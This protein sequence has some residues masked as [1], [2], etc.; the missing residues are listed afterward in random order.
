MWGWFAHINDSCGFLLQRGSNCAHWNPVL[1]PP[2]CW[3]ILWLYRDH[4]QVQDQGTKPGDPV[5]L[6]P[7]QVLSCSHPPSFLTSYLFPPVR[8]GAALHRSNS[9]VPLSGSYNIQPLMILE[10]AAGSDFTVTDLQGKSHT[11][12]GQTIKY[13][14]L[15]LLWIPGCCHDKLIPSY[16]YFF[17]G[18]SH[19]GQSKK[20]KGQVGRLPGNPTTYSRKHPHWAKGYTRNKGKQA[21]PSAN[22]WSQKYLQR[23][24]NGCRLLSISRPQAHQA[25]CM[26]LPAR[27]SHSSRSEGRVGAQQE[28]PMCFTEGSTQ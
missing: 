13:K 28:L 15:G 22:C 6:K 20:S 11:F 21:S 19:S 24:G 3:W 7:L 27:E 18:R 23:D 4:F 14:S 2:L 16:D 12:L 10:D 9:A 17:K 1:Q 26:E 5:I 25:T 8:W